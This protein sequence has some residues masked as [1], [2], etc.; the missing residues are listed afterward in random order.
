MRKIFYLFIGLLP[1][2]LNS[3]DKEPTAQFKIFTNRGD[4][5]FG[6]NETVVFDCEGY[7]GDNYRY[8]WDFGD[9]TVEDFE[10]HYLGGHYNGE[11]SEA[12]NQ[13][14]YTAPGT[15]KVRLTTWSK[16]GRK[17]D[18]R[19]LMVEVRETN[20]VMFY[21]SQDL[22][23]GYITVNFLD[24][25]QQITL[26][27]SITPSCGASGTA[28]F[29]NCPVG[30]EHGYSAYDYYHSWHHDVDVNDDITCKKVHLVLSSSKGESETGNENIVVAA[31]ETKK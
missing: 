12:K 29:T 27:H 31:A 20:D 24:Q 18:T 5:I 10:A 2:F 25:T 1:F 4:N 6:V 16:H 14:V 19:S 7:L 23:G 30:S 3:C 15:Y 9:G 17:S 8:R 26:I 21:I 11:A 28:Y 22:G 13:H